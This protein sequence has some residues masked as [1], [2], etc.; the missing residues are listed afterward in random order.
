MKLKKLRLYE[1]LVTAMQVSV[2]VIKRWLRHGIS[3]RPLILHG[4]SIESV[5][6]LLEKGSLPPTTKG[7]Y[8]KEQFYFTPVSRN[9]RELPYAIPLEGRYTKAQAIRSAKTYAEMGAQKFFLKQRLG[10]LQRTKA[11]DFSRRLAFVQVTSFR[12]RW[13]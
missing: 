6:V 11:S 8:L 2:D 13:L 12:S 4:T 7:R 10:F 3:E 9:F 1:K 5:S